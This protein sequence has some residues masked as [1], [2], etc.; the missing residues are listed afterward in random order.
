MEL[1]S[2]YD[3]AFKRYGTVL[4]DYDFTD[5]L[6][7]MKITPSPDEVEYAASVT[8]LEATE[9]AKLLKDNFFGGMPIEVGYCN[10]HN[11]TLNALEYHRDSELNIAATDAVLLVGDV[12]DITE[13]FTY[14]TKLV[15]AFF[16]P[17]G[18]GVQLYSTT[19]HYAPCSY[20]TDAFQ[21]AIVLPRG[22]NY[23]LSGKPLPQGEDQL[24]FAVNKWLM[25]HEEAGIPGAYIGL[26]G[27]NLKVSKEKYKIESR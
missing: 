9:T 19:L 23:N 13:D 11:W 15:E 10:G 22:T 21:V 25:A 5:L 27:E 16:L 26:I 12:H 4:K 14:D 17:A 1:K 18:T 20:G 6:E 2:V 8:W 3:K 24:L 7:A